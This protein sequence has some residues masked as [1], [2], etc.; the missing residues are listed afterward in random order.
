MKNYQVL[1]KCIALIAIFG[2]NVLY[3]QAQLTCTAKSQAGDPCGTES[4]NHSACTKTECPNSYSCS[5]TGGF[6]L[7]CTEFP[8]TAECQKL[9]ATGAW[10]QGEYGPVWVCN[11]LQLNG[12]VS[13]GACT[14]VY[15]LACP[16]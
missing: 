8:Y 12:T 7:D 15:T 3:V 14:G 11:D 2:I 1:S 4:Y 6:L 5:E 16:D 13:G 10:V 9:I